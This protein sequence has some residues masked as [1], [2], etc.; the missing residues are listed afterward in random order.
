MIFPGSRFDMTGNC[1]LN[2]QAN[3]CNRLQIKKYRKECIML[4]TAR[5]SFFT[6]L[7]FLL[8]F[9]FLLFPARAFAYSYTVSGWSDAEKTS[10][11]DGDDYMCWAASASNVL[12][13]TGWG[14]NY[15]TDADTIFDY[16]QEYWSNDG[17][18]VY[19]AWSW[20]FDGIDRRT[21]DDLRRKTSSSL[22]T[23]N[24][25]NFYDD[26]TFLDYFD[27]DLNTGS[28]MSS[29]ETYLISGYG[30]SLGIWGYDTSS[31]SEWGHALTIWGYD[32]NDDGEYLGIW[33]TDS[34]DY[35]D[36]LQYYELSYEED[37]YWLDDYG[38]SST[39][40]YVFGAYALAAV[41]VPLPSSLVILGFGL[42][43]MVLL[44]KRQI[45]AR[46][47]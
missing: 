18:N 4:L 22:N 32:Y 11:S 30:V 26:Y 43:T 33:V 28:I 9:C 20:W 5:D 17:G 7:I 2:L 29:V 15:S 37:M 39:N 10:V 1:I 13:Y 19:Y 6:G 16:F 31:N 23:I 46:T 35:E 38:S 8:A 34:D 36:C 44:R 27:Y 25:G 24:S 40:W 12:S 47:I 41:P 42:S 45:S 3:A 14:D 21:N